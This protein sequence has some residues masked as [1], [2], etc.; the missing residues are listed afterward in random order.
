M[1]DQLARHAAQIA[2]RLA[3]LPAEGSR[4][5]MQALDSVELLA[6]EILKDVSA[7]RAKKSRTLGESSG[8]WPAM[9]PLRR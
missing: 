2:L 3:A 5:D 9:Q 1:M 7:I 8:S 4:E 6:L